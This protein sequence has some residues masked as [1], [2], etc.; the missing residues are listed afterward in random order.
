MDRMNY[1]RGLIRYTTENALH[2]KKSSIFRPRV[3]IYAALLIILIAILATSLVT[4]T[5]V[6]LDIIRDRNTL[7]RELPGDIIENTYTLKLIN[8]HSA[9]REFL[10]EVSGVDRITLDGVP[11]PLVVEGGDVMSLP[12]RTRVP[13]EASYGIMDIQ[14]TVTA[15]DDPSVRVTED[16]RFL[17]PT[18]AR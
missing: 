1:P 18:T 10:L 9:A 5:P 8:Q 13:R 14:F 6:I 3:L 16:S 17:G 15:A 11:Q 4:R 7:F 2:D 12:V